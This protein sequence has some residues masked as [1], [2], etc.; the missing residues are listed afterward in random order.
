MA[1]TTIRT[2]EKEAAVLEALT[3][4]P[5]V[6]YAAR[7]A[8]VSRSALIAWLRD[9]PAFAAACKD[10]KQSGYQEVEDE[11]VDRALSGDTTALIFLLKSQVRETYG[12][13]IDHTHTV[14]IVFDPGWI[15]IRSALFDALLPYP[16]AL[17]AVTTR[18]AALGAGDG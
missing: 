14:N 2:P 5:T 11:L 10:A 17:A 18:L 7:R 4:K 8:R 6:R 3:L 9:D 1:N 16:D 12:D 15:T 13:R